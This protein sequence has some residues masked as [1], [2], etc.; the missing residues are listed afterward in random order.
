[1][2]TAHGP[3]PLLPHTVPVR[4]QKRPKT[5]SGG[6]LVV[7]VSSGAGQY[8]SLPLSTH[9]TSGEG[10]RR[11]E[12]GWAVVN[13]VM[14]WLVLPRVEYA[15]MHD[16]QVQLEEA[17]VAAGGGGADAEEGARPD[18]FFSAS[19]L[20]EMLR[21]AVGE[22]WQR[23]LPGCAVRDTARVLIIN[24]QNHWAVALQQPGGDWVVMDTQVPERRV[25]TVAAVRGL[26]RRQEAL[27]MLG[28]G[29]RGPSPA[30][31]GSSDSPRATG[32]EPANRVT[33][34]GT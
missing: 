11:S 2:V 10:V 25:A 8:P 31:G 9:S 19:C 1:M 32:R 27:Y 21:Q 5:D 7:D 15:A 18:G 24:R 6:D 13:W 4:G 20:G 34:G 17:E 12:C 3:D 28:L 16:L 29:G 23:L 30:V 33:Q 22:D 26:Y 14:D